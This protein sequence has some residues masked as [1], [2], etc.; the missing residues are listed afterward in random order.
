MVKLS[1]CFDGLPTNKTVEVVTHNF[2]F[3]GEMFV[4][5]VEPSRGESLKTEKRLD[6]F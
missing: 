1:H 4:D 5:I 6:F 3:W 2:L